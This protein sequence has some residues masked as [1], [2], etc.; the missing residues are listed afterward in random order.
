RTRTIIQ[1]LLILSLSTGMWTALFAIFTVITILRVPK[2]LHL[3]GLSFPL[4][5]LYCNTVLINL[6]ARQVI[7]KLERRPAHSQISFC[8]NTQWSCPTEISHG[9]N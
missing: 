1:K 7:E 9:S 3:C 2:C 6:N 5:P 8:R 4:C